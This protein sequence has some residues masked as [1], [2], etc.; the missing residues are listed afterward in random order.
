MR[1]LLETISDYIWGNGMIVLLLCAGLLCTVRTKCIQLK[2]PGFIFR[3]IRERSLGKDQLKIVC[4]SLGA[5]MGTGNITGVSAALLTCGPGAV[6]WMWISAFLG[7][8]LVYTENVLSSIYSSS[9]VKGSIAYIRYGLNSRILACLFSIFCCG[10]ACTMGGFVQ[11]NSVVQTF[12]ASG[13]SA[14]MIIAV[15]SF[16]LIIAV[17]TGGA[18]RIR[19]TAQF[20]LPFV[21]V[22]YLLICMIVIIRFRCNIVDSLKSIFVSAF[23]IKQAAGGIFGHTLSRIIST[24][25]RRG[26]FSNEAGLGSSPLLHSDAEMK[27]IS[28][29]GMWAMAEV[30]TD[31]IICCTITALTILCSDKDMSVITSFSSVLRQYTAPMLACILSVF[32]FC[33][34]IGWYYCGEKAFL[35]LTGGKHSKSAAY[36]FAVLASAGTLFSASDAW[37]LSDIFNGLM[38]I[39]NIIAVFLLSPHILSDRQTEL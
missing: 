3:T 31:T 17:I 6:F 2:L 14:R 30:F 25:L 15:L 26:I 24:G 8:A 18:D 10:T 35:Y 19:M 32:A 23:G 20:A 34:V 37:M 27:S 39:P 13:I 33:T 22:L 38:A 5:A 7:M 29:Q 21:S 28:D 16:F 36:I 4:T 9:K 1:I 11:V 12:E